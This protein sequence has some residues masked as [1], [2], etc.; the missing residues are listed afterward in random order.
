MGLK[1][2][3]GQ[4]GR[5]GNLPEQF[6]HGSAA[7]AA[8]ALNIELGSMYRARAS[9]VT[10]RPR[11]FRVIDSTNLVYAFRRRAT[12]PITPRPASISA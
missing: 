4:D 2:C 8:V 10:P 7:L 1:R 6:A 3:E 5:D 12:K 9:A 11:V